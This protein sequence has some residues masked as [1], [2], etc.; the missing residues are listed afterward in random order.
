MPLIEGKTIKVRDYVYIE[1]TYNEEKITLRIKKYKIIKSLDGK[2]VCRKCKIV[3]G[4]DKE[5][6]NLEKDPGELNNI[7][8][9]EKDA[10]NELDEKLEFLKKHFNSKREKSKIATAVSSIK[11]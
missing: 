10:Y 5:L 4:G 2:G 7:A 9:T 6:Y 8:E 11:A 3:H 1:E